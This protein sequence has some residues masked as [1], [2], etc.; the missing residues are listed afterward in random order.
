MTKVLAEFK[1][2]MTNK[3]KSHVPLQT[4]WVTVKE[5][6]WEEKTMTA[7]GLLNA[8]E[9]HDVLLGLGAVNYRPKIGTS[10]LVGS[11]H[12][13]EACFMISCEEIEEIEIIDESG[14]KLNLNNGLLLIN[15]EEFGGIVN[16]KELKTQADKNT[17]ILENIQTVFENWIPVANDGGA[18]LKALVTSFTSLERTDLSNIEN[19]TIKHGNG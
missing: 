5:I 3:M 15:G 1:N 13:G 12:N 19:I 4:E 18:S 7:I 11:I 10:A 8:L 2:L 16:A 14:F 9:Y 6:D 17:L